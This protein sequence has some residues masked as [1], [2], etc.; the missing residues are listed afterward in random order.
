MDI[1]CLKHRVGSLQVLL[2]SELDFQFSC[3]KKHQTNHIN[4]HSPFIIFICN[5][6]NQVP[7]VR[8]DWPVVWNISRFDMPCPKRAAD[9]G[10][11]LRPKSAGPPAGSCKGTRQFFSLSMSEATQ[12][13][14]E[15]SREKSYVNILVNICRIYGQYAVHN[16]SPSSFDSDSMRMG[17]VR[18]VS[19][20]MSK[21]SHPK[22]PVLSLDVIKLSLDGHLGDAGYQRW[23]NR[24][25]WW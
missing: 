15:K 1:P 6:I 2:I 25:K 23:I 5:Q 4:H 20:S 19:S 17:L 24:D 16:C 22:N 13:W 21:L 9:L 14:K 3:H 18:P 11:F 12:R 8:L 10:C 7:N